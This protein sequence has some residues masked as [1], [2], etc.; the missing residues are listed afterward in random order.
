VLHRLASLLETPLD[1]RVGVGSVLRLQARDLLER[2][3]DGGVRRSTRELRAH[4]GRD[5]LG[6]RTVSDHL[7]GEL[8]ERRGSSAGEHRR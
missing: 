7:D 5:T 1:D 3:T 8:R 4:A 6:E 2:A